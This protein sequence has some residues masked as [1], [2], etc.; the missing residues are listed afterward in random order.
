VRCGAIPPLLSGGGREAISLSKNQS[1]I[2]SGN[3]I[4]EFVL[5][6]VELSSFPPTKSISTRQYLFAI[7][8]SLFS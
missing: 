1:G 6:P 2:T 7:M 8:L 5:L 4:S 3:G